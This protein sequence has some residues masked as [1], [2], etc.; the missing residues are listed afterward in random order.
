[1][2]A[3]SLTVNGKA[4][5]TDVDTR[6]LLVSAGVD[7]V[8]VLCAFEPTVDFLGVGHPLNQLI[9]RRSIGHQE[10]EDLLRRLDEK[11]PLLV[12]GRLEE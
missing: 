4:V 2:A 6:T 12:L 5:T 11:L 9:W 7:E 1:M 3:V 10:R 8:R